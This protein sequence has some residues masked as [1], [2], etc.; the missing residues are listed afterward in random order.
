[1]LEAVLSIENSRRAENR[2]SRDV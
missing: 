2:S 1:M